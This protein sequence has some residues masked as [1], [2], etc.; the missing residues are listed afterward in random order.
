MEPMAWQSL[1]AHIAGS[2]R[3]PNACQMWQP[4]Q[5]TQVM[6][7]LGEAYPGDGLTHVPGWDRALCG[8]LQVTEE[9]LPRFTPRQLLLLLHGVA[10]VR[11][12]L[13]ALPVLDHIALQASRCVARGAY[14]LDDLLV[15]LWSS[16][17]AGHASH[18]LYDAIAEALLPAVDDLQLGGATLAAWCY[19]RHANYLHPTLTERL[20]HHCTVLLERDNKQATDARWLQ[21]G[22]WGVDAGV[23]VG[24]APRMQHPDLTQHGR[25]CSPFGPSHRWHQQGGPSFTP[26]PQQQQ[27]QQHHHH[28]CCY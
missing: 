15:L 2:T 1:V 25:D 9:Q 18:M 27:Q 7:A 13:P 4:Q 16:V 21:P 11:G 23:E 28:H 6:W 17:V 10:R 14:S 5:L 24:T 26:P 20:L 8:V 3:A 19:L 12:S 22:N